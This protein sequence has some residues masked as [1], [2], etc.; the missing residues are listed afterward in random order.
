[1]EY[2][3]KTSLLLLLFYLGYRVFLQKETF[4]SSN[5]WFLLVGLILSFSLPLIV[6]PIYE[7]QVVQ[8]TEAAPKYLSAQPVFKA[9]PNNAIVPEEPAFNWQVLLLRFYWIGTALFALRFLSQLISVVLIIKEGKR[10]FFKSCTIIETKRDLSPFS[11]FKAII[12]NPFGLSDTAIQQILT[13][14]KAHVKDWHSVDIVL[15]ELA[16]VFMWFNPLLWWYQKGLKQNLEFI[17]D[18]KS[19]QELPCSKTY[20]TV[21]VNRSLTNQHLALTNNFHNSFLKKRIIMLNRSKSNPFQRLKMVY[22]IPFLA[23]FLFNFS[24]E[25]HTRYVTEVIPPA[26]E[27]KA[28]QSQK[29]IRNSIEVLFTKETTEE[30]L[31]KIKKILKVEGVTMNI[32]EIQRGENNYITKIAIEF[33]TKNGSANYNVADPKGIAPF[34]FEMKDN[35]S[36][37]VGAVKNS[38]D[39]VGE[40]VSIKGNTH[41]QGTAGNVWI[42]NVWIEEDSDEIQIIEPDSTSGTKNFIIKEGD[43]VIYEVHEDIKVESKDGNQFVFR[44]PSSPDSV[45]TIKMD[46]LNLQYA[47]KTSPYIF[48]SEPNG[49]KV[50]SKSTTVTN[51][52]SNTK[53]L[54]IVDGKVIT[55]DKMNSLNTESIE[56]VDVLKDKAAV[57]LYGF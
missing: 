37:G 6:I 49:N 50:F 19:I 27:I 51:G 23:L 1:M 5:R 39:K 3:L 48:V 44:T 28:I 14:E 18:Q 29:E 20:Q 11:F 47:I 38:K 7:T 54:Y 33:N 22:I 53:P 52:M 31:E 9:V 13:H 55:S 12:Y 34:Y 30:S 25:T 10:T 17:A 16:L 57:A 56:S 42:G 45:F 4:F 36:F 32:I 15:S 41:N 24:T 2:L 43:D 26:H 46:S 21:L 40:K 8:V 35:G